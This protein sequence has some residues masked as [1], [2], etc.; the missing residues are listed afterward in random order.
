[1]RISVPWLAVAIAVGCTPL[2]PS[3]HDGG[4][5]P[6]DDGG[7]A[8]RICLDN[9]ADGVPGTGDCSEVPSPDCNDADPSI[10]PRAAEAC[11]EKDN[12]CNALVDDGLPM[13]E[14]FA[15]GDGDGYGAGTPERSCQAAMTNRVPK[16]G[17]C[18]DKDRNVFPNAPEACNEKDD[19][20]NGQL[21]DNVQLRDFFTDGDGD[22]FG[23][24]APTRSCQASLPGKVTQAGD[25]DDA[26]SSVN[27]NATEQCNGRDDDCDGQTDESF[28]N[29]GMACTTTRPGVCAPGTRQCV[30]GAEAC[31]SNV[32]PSAELCDGLDNDCD[33]AIDETFTNKGQGCTSGV[34]VCQRSGTYV[35]RADK[36]GTECSAMPGP[37]T[38]PACDGADNDCD[39]TVDEAELVR[40]DAL[41]TTDV[42][43]ADVAPVFYSATSCNG[44]QGT[45]GTDAFQRYVAAFLIGGKPHA[46]ELAGDGSSAQTAPTAVTTPYTSY[47][48]ISAAQAGS[49]VAIA[50]RWMTKYIDLY[51]VGAGPTT[52]AI[53]SGGETYFGLYGPAPGSVQNVKLV[54]GNGGRVVALWR[55]DDGG[56][57]KIRMARFRFAPNGSAYSVVTETA[58]KDLVATAGITGAFGAASSHEEYGDS[59]GCPQGLGRF[60]VAYRVGDQ[61]KLDVFNEDGTPAAA[62]N[63]FTL[64][65]GDANRQAQEPDVAWTYVS[66]D[67]WAAA[68][69]V[70]WSSTNDEAVY[71][72]HSGGSFAVF[73]PWYTGNGSSS[74]LQPVIVARPTEFLLGALAHGT[75]TAADEPQVYLGKAS[76]TGQVVMPMTRVT[77]GSGC[78]GASCANGTKKLLRLIPSASGPSKTNGA[79]LYGSS[80]GQAT[81]SVLGCN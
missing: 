34:G 46:Q 44:G 56:T 43:A 28:P 21:D 53:G 73:S 15:D 70:A 60:A 26:L 41:S 24:G 80:L 36:T 59:L 58:P 61:L 65:T 67:R 39:G 32:G 5:G 6:T 2:P 16:G 52:R 23:A 3:R 49:G 48:E 57:V 45:S 78:T 42:T 27:P 9:D 77:V 18:D 74:V 47:N 64:Y 63:A 7:T 76:H 51:Y 4:S 38:A 71:F 25:C 13:N 75:A 12:D 10:S 55:E 37:P 35:C 54:R 62:P 31:V 81:S 17:D 29:R 14:F 79:A 50:V 69:S 8:N 11:D 20:C 22:G 33:N 30:G 40:H 66:G 1:M 19:N 72:W 68:F